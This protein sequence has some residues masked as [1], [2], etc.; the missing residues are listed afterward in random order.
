MICNCHVYDIFQPIFSIDDSPNLLPKLAPLKEPFLAETVPS[1][2][3]T[4]LKY[5]VFAETPFALTVKYRLSGSHTLK[6][7]FTINQ[8]P[9][10]TV[11]PSNKMG[12]S[13]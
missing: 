12:L 2:T 11:L 8:L 7:C 4:S 5:P 1:L 6:P 10:Q 13:E 3:S 9:I